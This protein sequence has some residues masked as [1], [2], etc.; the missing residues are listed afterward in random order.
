MWSRNRVSQLAKNNTWAKIITSETRKN[1]SKENTS[2]K[3]NSMNN[4]QQGEISIHNE[5]VQSHQI[6][7]Q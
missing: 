6:F 3:Q 1:R 2:K 5:D 7:G 4:K